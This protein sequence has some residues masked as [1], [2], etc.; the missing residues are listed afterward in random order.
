MSGARPK[1]ACLLK[2]RVLQTLADG[3]RQK[4]RQLGRIHPRVTLR[5][6]NMASN[7][8][9]PPPQ[10][11]EPPMSSPFQALPDDLLQRVLA[12]V[13]L[14]DQQATAAVCEDFRAVIRGPGFLKLR[15]VHGFAERG[16]VVVGAPHR[17]EYT[18]ESS[19]AFA[20]AQ[21]PL[22]ICVAHKRRE[23]TGVLADFSGHFEVDPR[24]STTD[25]G[26]RLFVS[27]TGPNQILAINASSRRWRRLTKTP[28]GQEAHCMEWCGGRLYVAG[29]YKRSSRGGYLNSLHVFDETTGLWGALPPMPHACNISVSGVIGNELFLAGGS[30]ARRFIDTLQIYDTVARAWRIGAPA[31]HPIGGECGVVLDGKF[32][33]IATDFTMVYDP[34]SDTW[35]EQRRPPDGEWDV[36]HACAHDG[37]IIVFKENGW[38]YTRP[39]QQKWSVSPYAKIED[40]K[41]HDF[42]SGSVVLG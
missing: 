21:T 20:A 34:Q 37:R 19:A 9:A 7:H 36:I 2:A 24:A 5:A 17:R 3:G 32:Y 27:T 33:V 1:M 35:T 28:L 40:A 6:W 23:K 12:G 22:R 31:P 29:G 11:L 26:A 39:V 14:D 25:G 13:P 4:S 18:W 10:V 42:A 30:T 15:Q 38:A 41:A 8:S 16:I